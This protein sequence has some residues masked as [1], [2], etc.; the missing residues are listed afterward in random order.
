MFAFKSIRGSYAPVYALVLFALLTLAIDHFLSM[1]K[2][3][4]KKKKKKQ[5]PLTHYKFTKL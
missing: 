4:Q 2:K 3:K 5:K 1:S